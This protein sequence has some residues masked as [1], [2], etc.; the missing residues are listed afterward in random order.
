MR[1][2]RYA[3]M[4]LAFVALDA[5]AHA[6]SAVGWVEPE[7]QRIRIVNNAA[8][9]Q[10]QVR[11]ADDWETADYLAFRWHDLQ[12]EMVYVTANNH[13]VA[14]DFPL[15]S[16]EIPRLFHAGQAGEVTLGESGSGAFLLGTVFGQRFTVEGSP[17]QCFSFK[18]SEPQRVLYG[19]ACSNSKTARPEI[20][21][22]LRDVRFVGRGFLDDAAIAAMEETD[23]EGAR[24][25]ALGRTAEASSGRGLVDLPLGYATWDPVGGS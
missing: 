12:G 14:I 19:Y 13:R 10:R 1:I 22:F 20:E 11:F 9:E 21:Q 15:T 24:Q 23:A 6:Q 18:S 7:R 17:L 4:A 3:A 2:C 25:F 16:G 5:P 8:Q